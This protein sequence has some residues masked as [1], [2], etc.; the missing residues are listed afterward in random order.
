MSTSPV[1]RSEFINRNWRQE[2][3][4]ADVPTYVFYDD[5]ERLPDGRRRP[6][7]DEAKAKRICAGC[8]VAVECLDDALRRNDKHGMHGGLNEAEKKAER[9]RRIRSRTL[10]AA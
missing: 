5:K 6:R 10:F 4:C 3:A 7:Y 9:R 1:P 2:A 8:P